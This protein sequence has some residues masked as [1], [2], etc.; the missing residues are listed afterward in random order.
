MRQA[1][2]CRCPRCHTGALY[3]PGFLSV[4]VVERCG[5]CGLDLSQED[6][7]DGPAVFLIFILGALLVPLALL[8]EFTVHPPLAVHAVLW[9]VVGLGLTLGALRPLKSYIIALQYKHRPHDLDS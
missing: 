3:K 5:S 6:S 2:A 7:A 8:L 1:W 4:A 9:G